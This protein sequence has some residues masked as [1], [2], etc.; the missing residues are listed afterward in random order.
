[1][2]VS[3]LMCVY[4]GEKYLKNVIESILSQTYTNFEFIIVDD[5]SLDDSLEIIKSY[6]KNDN[7]I[8]ILRNKSN[9]GLTRSLNK[10]IKICRGDLIARQDVDDLS[11]PTRFEKQV[12]FLERNKD[13][14]FCGTNGIQKPHN[15]ELAKFF[16]LAE[17]KRYLMV[18][19]CFFHPTI[20]IRKNIF[21]KYGYYN[22]K[23]HYGQDYELW[24]RL[25]Y[26]Y[27]LKAKN[28]N[29]KL[30]IMNMNYKAFRKT[31]INKFLIQRY[32]SI[33]SKI[34]Y[35]RYMKYKLKCLLSI[36]IRLLEMITRSHLMGK[37]SK[38]LYKINF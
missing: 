5:G 13:F 14:A 21:E 17:I 11:V 9:I 32:N 28:I 1:M 27:N 20:M 30:V 33:R 8:K 3:V 34:L 22:E 24:C 23:F 19:N 7:R 2:K 12:I 37:F 15:L 31:D 36:L 38:F 16:K 29:D 4:N 18:E 6:A 10:A 35:I 26:K 25:I